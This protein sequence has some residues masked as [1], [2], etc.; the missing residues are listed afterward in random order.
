MKLH[1]F[2]PVVLALAA[3]LAADAQLIPAPQSFAYVLQADILARTKAAAVSKLTTSGRDWIILDA[4]YTGGQNWTAGDIATIRAGKPGRKVVAY[5]S[6]GEAETYRSYWNASWDADLNGEP[7]AGAPGWLLGENPFWAGNYVVKYWDPTWQS[8]I[9]QSLDAILA[10]G[11]DGI[12]LDIVD[13]FQ[14]FEYDQETGEWRDYLVNPETGLTYRKD[15][16]NWVAR[17]AQYARQRTTQ[18]FLVVP[19][20]GEQLLEDASHLA[21]ISAQGAESVF[22]DGNATIPN[23]DRNYRLSFLTKATAAAKPV[24][25]VEYGTTASAKKKSRN[26]A[27]ANKFVLLLTSYDLGKL[28][29]Q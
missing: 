29:S 7:D 28:G 17:L 11:F 14:N 9:L 21:Q 2:L 8:L 10:A 4:A 13:G 26:G 3:P 23:A 25:L 18:N 20:N 19:Q 12:Y 27:A 22:T 6:I 24:L 1:S 5:L 16:V 15:M